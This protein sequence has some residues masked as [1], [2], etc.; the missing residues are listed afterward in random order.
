MLKILTLL[1]ILSSS[2]FAAEIVLVQEGF[3]ATCKSKLDSYNSKK[4]NV[5][6]L[7]DFTVVD[8]G[9]TVELALE[10]EFLDC[11]N[12]DGKYVFVSAV[13]H[14]NS[15]YDVPR[16]DAPAIT[17]YRQD[18]KKDI[19]ALNDMLAVVSTKVLNSDVNAQTVS[20]EIPKTQLAVNNFPLAQDK[21]THYI[22]VMVRSYTHVFTNSYDYGRSREA[23]GMFRVFLNLK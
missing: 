6:T 5:Y 10:V 17:V 9:R 11:V 18:S 8:A 23:G 15:Q 19:V 4:A 20:L 22:D 3:K 16:I 14:M 12:Q 2:A 13:D 7:N 1:S 21:G